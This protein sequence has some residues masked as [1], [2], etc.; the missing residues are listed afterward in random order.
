[1]SGIPPK[2]SLDFEHAFGFLSENS[3]S[4]AMEV[5]ETSLLRAAQAA[6]TRDPS[7]DE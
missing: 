1:M 3:V 4:T 6:L 7:E 5:R 2:W